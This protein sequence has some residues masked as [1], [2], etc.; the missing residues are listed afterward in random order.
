MAARSPLAVIATLTTLALQAS[1]APA[2]RAS[3]LFSSYEV[4][5]LKLEAP[6]NDLFEHA[7]SRANAE[8]AVSGTLSY[9][10][11]GR[12]V[13][14]DGVKVAVRG[15]T[16][17]R[18]TECA[19]PKLKVQLPAGAPAGALLSGLTS[20]KIGTHCGESAG[21][22]LTAKYGRLSNQQ[23]PLREAFV[24]RLLESVGVPTLK[25]RPAKVAYVYAD[26]RPEQSPPQEQP[27]VRNAMLLEDVD[28]AVKRFGGVREIEEKAFTNAKAQFSAADTARIALA[29]AM[30]GNFDWCLKMT[31]DDAYRCNARHPLWNIVAAAAADGKARP[32]MYDFDIAGMVAGS[33]AWFKNVF[34]AA[35]VPSRSEIEVEVLAQVQRTRVLFSRAELDAARADF[36]KRKPDAYRTLAEATIDAAGKRRAQEYLDAFYAAI[37][38]DDAFY[39]P[40]VTAE[41]TRLYSNKDR[42]V[43]CSSRGVIP[44][45]T[46]VSA[47]LQTEGTVIQVHVLDALWYWQEPA[48]CPAVR[49]GPV[50]IDA[51]AVSRD[52]PK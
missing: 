1:A 46:P 41:E 37:G 45:G 28:A 43:V 20:L 14:V 9:T 47:P 21:D 42:A 31:A 3:P 17:R 5:E 19:F 16:S 26:R 10:D 50:W 24:Y 44:V 18:E 51:D 29:E 15:N 22:S 4:I 2:E 25:A 52:F 13:T 33:H 11:G 40:V 48:R 35:F 8:Y 6:F 30:I 36:V 49:E 34:N 23:S 7:R 12:E 27:I 38:S 32:L 39:R